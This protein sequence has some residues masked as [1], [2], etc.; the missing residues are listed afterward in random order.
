MR[1]VLRQVL[2]RRW[3]GQN[4]VTTGKTAEQERGWLCLGRGKLG[5]QG[6]V[7]GGEPA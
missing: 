2:E 4:G 1:Q 3:S 7:R 6:L 5:C